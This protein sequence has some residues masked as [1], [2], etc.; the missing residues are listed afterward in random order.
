MNKNDLNE[1]ISNIKI[2]LNSL[3]YIDNSINIK[4][5]KLSSLTDC[6]R[7]LDELLNRKP[8]KSL[9]YVG[10]SAFSHKGGLHVS[11]VKKDPKTYEHVD[12][13]TVGNHRNI[14]I[15]NNNKHIILIRNPQDTI[16][17]IINLSN[18][19]NMPMSQETVTSIYMDRLNYL[20]EFISL[21]KPSNWFF[22]DYD[23]L[24]EKPDEIL[25]N[26][27]VFLNLKNPLKKEYQLK[28]YT[29][30]WGDPSSNITKGTIFKTNS[31]AITIH[32]DLLDNASKA[33]KNAYHFFKE[34][35]LNNF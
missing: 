35:S 6:S 27:S 5:E 2:L 16:S 31:K 30:K 1:D 19:K 26:L 14:I 12:P 11:A 17:S 18:H 7:L 15:S 28:K 24:I 4:K 13:K 8:N 32:D 23:E 29:Q 9:P 21:L 34:K 3:G 10:A 20:I 22:I 33:Y 25:N